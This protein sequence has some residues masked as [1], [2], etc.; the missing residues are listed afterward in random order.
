MPKKSRRKAIRMKEKVVISFPDVKP[1][2]LNIFSYS[3]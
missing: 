1:L 3:F 2:A